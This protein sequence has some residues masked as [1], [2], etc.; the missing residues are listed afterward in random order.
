MR[1]VVFLPEA[2]KDYV[3]WSHANKDV[4]SK[5]NELISEIQREPFL[6]IGKPEPLKGNLKGCWSRRINLEH[7]MVYMVS[8]TQ[9]TI[10]SCHGHYD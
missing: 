3:D 7:R 4:F 10:V 2:F 9:V 1:S 8:A 6:G 5:I